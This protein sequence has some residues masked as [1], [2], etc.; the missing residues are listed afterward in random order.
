[1]LEGK[2]AAGAPGPVPV[3]K[4]QA[5]APEEPIK[6]SEPD[7][8]SDIVA[9]NRKKYASLTEKTFKGWLKNNWDEVQAMPEENRFEIKTK[10]QELY[11][12]PFPAETPT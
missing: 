2:G 9:T 1:M 7:I 10:Y 11:E 3:T 4:E 6:A 12:T 5:P 8:T